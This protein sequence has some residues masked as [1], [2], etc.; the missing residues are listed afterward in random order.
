MRAKLDFDFDKIRECGLPD[1]LLSGIFRVPLIDVDVFSIERYDGL[2]VIASSFTLEIPFNDHLHHRRVQLMHPFGIFPYDAYKTET[3]KEREREGWKGFALAAKATYKEVELIKNS[4]LQY[5]IQGT[6]S[7]IDF[8][9][10]CENLKDL[11]KEVKEQ[12]KNTFCGRTCLVQIVDAGAKDHTGVKRNFALN[13]F[14]SDQ[15]GNM[16]FKAYK[17]NLKNDFSLSSVG[18]GFSFVG[19]GATK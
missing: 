19:Y 13:Q 17:E 9:R 11:M 16:I 12:F 15:A 6:Q 3:I 8:Y 14:L 2:K 4:F 7:T 1:V 10:Q 18:A 5:P